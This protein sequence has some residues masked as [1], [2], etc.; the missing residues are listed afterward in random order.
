MTQNV[1][2]QTVDALLSRIDDLLSGAERAAVGHESV[3]G[4]IDALDDVHTVADSVEDLLGT[5]DLTQLLGEIEWTA[6]PDAIKLERVPDAIE[7]RNPTVAVKL[8]KLLSV[9]DM[10]DVWDAVDAR[11][12]WRQ[13]RELD[14]ELDD[15]D[16]ESDGGFFEGISLDGPFSDDGAADDGAA[17]E[18]ADDGLDGLGPDDGG[19]DPESLENA[20]QSQISDSV[21]SFRERILEARERLKQL[22]EENIERSEQRHSKTSNSRNPTAVSTTSSQRPSPGR[23]AFSTVPEETRYSTAPNRRRIYGSRFDDGESDE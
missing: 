21:G 11:A 5:V 18:T 2:G 13:S 15:F 20:L 10:S 17:G 4:A 9:T 12:F 16:E 19:F 6:L 8:R 22:R 14:D 23:A 7:E 1:R 3:E